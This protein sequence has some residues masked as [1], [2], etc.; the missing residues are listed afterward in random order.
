MQHRYEKENKVTRFEESQL[1]CF[2][3]VPMVFECNK[4]ETDKIRTLYIHAYRI[5]FI[6]YC[7]PLP[8]SFLVKIKI[9]QI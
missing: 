5:S 4:I 7:P 1:P 8:S 3:T 6:S 2:L 9:T